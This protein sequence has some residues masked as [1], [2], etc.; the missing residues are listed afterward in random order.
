[1]SLRNLRPE[2]PGICPALSNG[3]YTTAGDVC[4]GITQDAAAVYALIRSGGRR[5]N[6]RLNVGAAVTVTRVV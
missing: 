5:N 2:A 4:D 6:N 3:C 1:M